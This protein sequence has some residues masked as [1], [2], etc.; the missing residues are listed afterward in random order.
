MIE[1]IAK[2]IAERRMAA[3]AILAIESLKPLNFIGSQVMHFLSPFAQ[4]IF[5]KDEYEEFAALIENDEYLHL[6]VKRI[7]ELDIEIF[8][9]ERK[10]AKLKRQKKWKRFKEIFINIF[11]KNKKNGGKV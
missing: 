4:V 3:P 11:N 9:K 10:Q 1:K 5:N 2:A 6:L 7:D 8:A